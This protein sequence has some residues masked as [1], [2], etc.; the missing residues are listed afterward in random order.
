MNVRVA[1][2]QNSTLEEA[3]VAGGGTGTGARQSHKV[4]RAA[5]PARED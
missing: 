4:R 1:S 3:G 5:A 2:L